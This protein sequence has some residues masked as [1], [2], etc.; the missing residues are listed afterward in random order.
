MSLIQILAER[1]SGL[2]RT[3]I[4][5]SMQLKCYYLK[6]DSKTIKGILLYAAHGVVVW[7]IAECNSCGPMT[8]Q[9]IAIE[10]KWEGAS[11]DI[12][13]KVEWLK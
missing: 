7:V 6:K 11:L 8:I 9:K 2:A 13:E 5:P 3:E 1:L 4:H 12:E 10:S